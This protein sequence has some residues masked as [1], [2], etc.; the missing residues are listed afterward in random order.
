MGAALDPEVLSAF[1]SRRAR[2]VRKFEAGRYAEPP[3]CLH[4]RRRASACM[5]NLMKGRKPTPTSLRI[6][7]GNPGK[8]ALP[9]DEARPDSVLPKPPSHLDR[10]GRTEWRRVGRELEALGLVSTID[11]ALLAAY[12]AA[13]SRLVD[14][15]AHL[16][17]SGSIVIAANG[18]IAQSPYLQ[19]ANKAIDQ[20]ARLA[21]EFGMSPSSRSRVRATKPKQEI[22]EEDRWEGLLS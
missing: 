11:R 4:A 22:A 2:G 3:R 19:I 16:R 1:M 13:W 14:A 21:P 15:E 6:L 7:R 8:R 17:D 18:A 12:C 20:L 9:T 5:L 10:E